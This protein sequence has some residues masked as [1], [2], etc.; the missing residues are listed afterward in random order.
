[1]VK[2][3]GPAVQIA[4]WLDLPSV[5]Q[6]L[7]V[8]PRFLTGKMRNNNNSTYLKERSRGLNEKTFNVLAYCLRSVLAS[9]FIGFIVSISD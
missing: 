2:N 5:G 7:S 1:M 4:V 8:C 6:V 9:V 3:L